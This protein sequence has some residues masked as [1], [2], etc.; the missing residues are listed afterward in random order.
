MTY[1]EDFATMSRYPT[2]MP[3]EVTVLVAGLPLP[4]GAVLDQLSFEV[5]DNDATVDV[6]VEYF[7]CSGGAT[8]GGICALLGSLQ[9]TG[10]PGWQWLS[11]GEIGLTG[12]NVN[13]YFLLRIYLPVGNSGGS[14]EFRRAV[15][16]YHL[17][18]SPAPATAT[19]TDVPTSSP[20]FQFVEAMA[21][22]GIT[23]GCGGENYCPDSPITRGQVAVILAKAL[24]IYW[25]TTP[26]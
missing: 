22:A 15:A 9:T 3:P 24:G 6:E 4:S 23:A 25:P 2:G 11:T 8:A 10:Q 20:Y 19:F 26:Q 18:V 12:D 13:T 21:A 5:W 16:Y 7:S 14:T 17:Q 1:G